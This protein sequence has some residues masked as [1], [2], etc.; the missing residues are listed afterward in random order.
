MVYSWVLLGLPFDVFYLYLLYFPFSWS[1]QSIS[2]NILLGSLTSS[3]SL[4]TV[5]LCM[6]PNTWGEMAHSSFTT[7]YVSEEMREILHSGFI[8]P[9]NWYLHAVHRPDCTC[10][11]STHKIE[12]LWWKRAS[13]NYHLLNVLIFWKRGICNLNI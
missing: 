11:N 9:S 4:D 5:G 6:Q 3:S 2:E 13:L 8:F 12:T 7:L 1:S 10:Q